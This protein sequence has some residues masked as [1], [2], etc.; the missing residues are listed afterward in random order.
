MYI[1]SSSMEEIHKH[2]MSDLQ[3]LWPTKMKANRHL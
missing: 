3:N 2:N 1:G